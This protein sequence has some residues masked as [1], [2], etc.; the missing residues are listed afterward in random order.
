ME[1]GPSPGRARPGK[2][3]KTPFGSLPTQPASLGQEPYLQSQCD[4][5]SYHLDPDSPVRI[6]NLHCPDGHTEPVVLPMIHSCQCSACQ[7]GSGWGGRGT[8]SEF[9]LRRGGL[10]NMHSLW[11]H[12]TLALPV[13]SDP[14]PPLCLFPFQLHINLGVFSRLYLIQISVFC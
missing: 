7:G 2:G 9:S 11:S 8:R 4:C 10:R 12:S 13:Y 14:P 3:T 1:L 6:L 5:C